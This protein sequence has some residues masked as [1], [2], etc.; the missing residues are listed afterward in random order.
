[1]QTL[2]AILTIENLPVESLLELCLRWVR[3]LVLLKSVDLADLGR[4]AFHL[5]RPPNCSFDRLGSGHLSCS[6]V[7]LAPASQKGKWENLQ[8]I[9]GG[10]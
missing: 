2:Q 9:Q 1:M 4:G 10:K 7:S 6:I 3:P 5:C 8:G